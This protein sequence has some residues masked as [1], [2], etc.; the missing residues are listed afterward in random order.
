MTDHSEA[1]KQAAPWVAMYHAITE[2]SPVIWRA[3]IASA[4]ERNPEVSLDEP[5]SL[6]AFL[7]SLTDV[8][9]QRGARIV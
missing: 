6:R 3:A 7:V 9:T 4:R 2:T 1:L 8:M 5:E